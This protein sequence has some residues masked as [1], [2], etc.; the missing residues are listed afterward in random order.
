VAKENKQ[1]LPEPALKYQRVEVASLDKGRRGKHHELVQGILSELEMLAPGS[2]LEIPLSE[3]GGIGLPNLRSAVHRA[4]TS[5]GL[6][7]ETLADEKHFYVW[8]TTKK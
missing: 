8:K 3:V 2:A 5:Q 1:N 4:S 7:I 6:S